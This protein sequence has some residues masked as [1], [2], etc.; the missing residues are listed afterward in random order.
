MPY[1]NA[2]LLLNTD[3]FTGPPPVLPVH[4]Q[5]KQTAQGPGQIASPKAQ[6]ADCRR[7]RTWHPSLPAPARHFWSRRSTG[8]LWQTS[9]QDVLRVENELLLPN[10]C[11][12]HSKTHLKIITGGIGQRQIR[13]IGDKKIGWNTENSPEKLGW[14]PKM[15]FLK[16]LWMSN[17]PLLLST[18]QKW[19]ELLRSTEKVSAD[20]GFQKKRKQ[21]LHMQLE[22]TILRSY[23]Y[24]GS[25]CTSEKKTFKK[26]SGMWTGTKWVRPLGRKAALRAACRPATASR[27][28]SRSPRRWAASS[29]SWRSASRAW[30]WPP[31]HAS[32][33]PEKAHICRRAAGDRALPVM[34]S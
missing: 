23:T 24:V 9:A 8:R 21:G 16:D 32:S 4:T 15:T 33:C 12:M 28:A 27:R 5:S 10:Q 34:A 17:H 20:T 14:F 1:H 6:Q 19:S 2:T 31:D 3:P 29:R 30:A 11:S 22:E 26:T 13:W 25:I 7:W 18:T